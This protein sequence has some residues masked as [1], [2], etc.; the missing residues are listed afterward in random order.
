MSRHNSRLTAEILD[1]VV[2]AWCLKLFSKCTKCFKTKPLSYDQLMG[3]VPESRIIPARSFTCTAIDYMSPFLIKNDH[4]RTTMTL[5]SYVT[6]F[7]CFAT[8][9]VH[10]EL[11]CDCTRST[12]LNALKRFKGANRELSNLFQS[13]NFTSQVI[14]SS[15]EEIKWQFIPLKSS[16]KNGLAEAGL[17]SVKTH[18]KRI[19]SNTLSFWTKI[20]TILPF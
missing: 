18:L 20:H 16:H 2:A 1:C 15:N 14:N 19:L 9:A 3:E 10:L 7:V 8:K 12:F 17:K 13:Q 6:I 4:L 5:K 11:V